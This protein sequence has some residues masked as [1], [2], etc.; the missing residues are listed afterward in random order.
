MKSLLLEVSNRLRYT[1]QS[2]NCL[3]KARKTVK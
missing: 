1:R 2:S 3:V